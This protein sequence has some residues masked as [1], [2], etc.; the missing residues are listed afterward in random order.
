MANAPTD[1]PVL[2]RFVAQIGPIAQQLGIKSFAFIG[3]DPSTKAQMFYGSPNA[4]AELRTIAGLKF[5]LGDS[6]ET[7]WE[8]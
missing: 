1:A 7:G 5:G 8:G 6:S 2:D 3:I 4:K